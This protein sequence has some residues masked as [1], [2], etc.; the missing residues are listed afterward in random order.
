MKTKLIKGA[1]M[2]LLAV[3][4]ITSSG[5]FGEFALTRKIYT[6]NAGI[7]GDDL[8]GKFVK[9]LVMYGLFIIPVYE[10]GGAVD[11]I[12][13]NLIEFW[14]GSNPM[15]MK[16]GQIEQRVINYKGTKYEVTAT[17]NNFHIVPME[18]VDKGKA[19]D[20]VFDVASQSWTLTNQ[21]GS[22][23]IIDVKGDK[24]SFYSSRGVV[25]KSLASIN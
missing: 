13:L 15:A 23:K 4:S 18:G 7:G 5:C 22:Q 10:I 8:G 12:I 3:F 9:T 2:L 17:K 11:F 20:L 14:T 25:T 1:A 24:V 16:E 21:E 6:W 19:T